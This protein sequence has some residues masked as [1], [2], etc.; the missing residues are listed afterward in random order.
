MLA[1]GGLSVL[2]ALALRFVET[3]AEAAGTGLSAAAAVSEPA[4]DLSGFFDAAGK[5]LDP[6]ALR[7]QVVVLNLLAT[8]CAP[9]LAELPA[10][11][12]LADAG[13]KDGGWAV[14]GLVADLKTS[15]ELAA[16]AAKHTISFPLY[17]LPQGGLERRMRVVGYPTTLL[18]GADG[19]VAQRVMGPE[20]WDSPAWQARLRA[21]GEPA[22]HVQ[23]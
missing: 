10:L 20:E 18:L 16:F 5:P 4:P 13:R 19:A 9:C 23:P 12:R 15:P 8:W 21:L 3:P 14:V 2:L 6:A 11:A 22:E 17:V 1:A 7:G